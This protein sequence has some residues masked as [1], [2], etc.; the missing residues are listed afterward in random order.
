MWT[1]PA[2]LHSQNTFQKRHETNWSGYL[3]INTISQ[4][5]S[6]IYHPPKQ[7]GC[8]EVSKIASH[9]SYPVQGSHFEP[10]LT[11][12]RINN[13]YIPYRD[14]NQP[15]RCYMH[16]IFVRMKSYYTS[17]YMHQIFVRMKSYY[18]NVYM[19][20]IFVRMKSYY[21]NVFGMKHESKV[22][23]T[24]DDFVRKMGAPWLATSR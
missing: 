2:I 9:M 7:L 18:T 14:G 11:C 10:S 13:G 15:W 17:V 12:G 16:Q 24:L 21:T 3:C 5:N 6:W 19:H 4:E 8:Q 1:L 23:H 20:Q 22:P